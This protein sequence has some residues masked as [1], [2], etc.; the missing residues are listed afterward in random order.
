MAGFSVC[1][2]AY[3]EPMSTSFAEY[4]AE[5]REQKALAIVGACTTA[6]LSADDVAHLGHPGRRELEKAAGVP[7]GSPT[8]WRL[9]VSFMAG[10]VTALCPFCVRG[11]DPEGVPGEPLFYGHLGPCRS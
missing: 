11:G 8:T 4:H 3:T 2:P 1:A 5:L 7:Y 9:V 10:S 6:G